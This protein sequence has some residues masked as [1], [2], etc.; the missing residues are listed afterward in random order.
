ML[1]RTSFLVLTACICSLSYAV[2]YLSL[3][4]PGGR[5]VLERTTVAWV[6]LG[7]AIGG[8]VVLALGMFVRSIIKPWRRHTTVF[9]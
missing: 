9:K 8:L 4:A 5:I 7:V 6:S 2:L 3:S 1:T